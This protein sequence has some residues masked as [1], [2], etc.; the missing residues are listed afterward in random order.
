MM[1]VDINRSTVPE[2]TTEQMIEVDRAMIEDYGITLIQMMENAGRGLAMLSRHTLADDLNGKHIMV[3][4][5]SGGNG[6]GAMVAARR[7]S[8]WGA[9]VEVC[10]TRALSDYSG[11]PAHQL[12]ILQSMNIPVNNRL[13]DKSYQ[14]ELILDGV[15]GYSLKG[16]PRGLAAELITWAQQQETSIL[17]LD[18]PSGLD[19][20]SG[21]AFEP[22]IN[23]TATLTLALPKI[24]L[25]HPRVGTLYLADISVPVDLYTKYLGIELPRLFARSDI[26]RL[27]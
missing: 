10:V 14:P 6:G 19:T 23:A 20:T 13:P 12:Q 21:E 9:D 3:L 15:L 27:I 11:V 8:A 18:T 26:V 2:I 4:A 22:G 1:L 17:S 16:S 24:G 7:L 25:Q 5:G